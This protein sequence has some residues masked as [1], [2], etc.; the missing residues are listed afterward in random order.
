VVTA[1]GFWH[2]AQMM[3]F[4]SFLTGEEVS[5]SIRDPL[6]LPLGIQHNC[7][8]TNTGGH[9][10]YWLA[11]HIVPPTD[12]F[13]T[14]TFK[15]VAMAAGPALVFLLGRWTY[16]MG[17]WAS[18]ASAITLATLPG[19]LSFSWLAIESGLDLILGLAG[20]L[21]AT[22]Q[23]ALARFYAWPLVTAGLLTYGGGLVF[24]GA[25]GVWTLWDLWHTYTCDRQRWTQRAAEWTIAVVF[26]GGLIL[27]C[28]SLHKNSHRAMQGGGTF[29]LGEGAFERAWTRL[30]GLSH[31]IFSSSDHSYYYF[32]VLP[33]HIH[34]LWVLLAVVG[35]WGFFCGKKSTGLSLV[36]IALLTISL[37]MTGFI[38][39]VP[40]YRRVVVLTVIHA[41]G[42]GLF[43]ELV[44]QKLRLQWLKKETM[45]LITSLLFMTVGLTTGW[46]QWHQGPHV[47]RILPRDYFFPDDLWPSVHDPSAFS[48]PWEVNDELLKRPDAIRYLSFLSAIQI[49]KGGDHRKIMDRVVRYFKTADEERYIMCP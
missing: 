35:L 30:F 8:A 21:C 2:F 11:M 15:S 4:Q 6:L 48:R 9:I 41:L 5:A 37:A 32:S 39:G 34:W 29:D 18:L 26:S 12:F 16:Q 24:V 49:R 47:R 44:T 28:Q 22:R 23:N 20:L 13:W 36:L 43:I 38:G 10:L 31:D 3:S 17:F 40:G 1:I 33:A 19:Y 42:L 46:H 27:L 45:A 14:R 7:Y 25:L